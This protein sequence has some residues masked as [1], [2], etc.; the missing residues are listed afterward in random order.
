MSM[1][2]D[3]DD[4]R[5]RL[6]EAV[7]AR[8]DG[9]PE[10]SAAR[11]EAML[12]DFPGD[13]AVTLEYAR[14]MT[15]LGKAELADPP[16]E[17]AIEK[18]P[19]NFELRAMWA[20]MPLFDCDWTELG[21]RGNT[22]RATFSAEQSAYHLIHE[23]LAL[24]ESFR[25]DDAAALVR[26]HWDVF[27]KTPRIFYHAID[28]LSSAVRTDELEAFLDAASF[29]AWSELP[30]EAPGNLRLRVEATR[31]NQA[32]IKASGVRLISLGQNC[33]PF[34][35][36]RRWGLNTP[37]HDFETLCPFDQ[38]A[39]HA[40][41]V[42]DAIATDFAA[43][44]DRDAY[45]PA[46]NHITRGYTLRHIPSAVPFYH[47]RGPYWLDN[48]RRRFFAH[49]ETMVENWRRLHKRGR[50]LFVFSLV[51]AGDLKRLID[52]AE[53]QLLDSQSHLLIIDVQKHRTECPVHERVTYLYAPYPDDYDW[54]SVP[55]QN[56]VGGIRF[57]S[58]I[59]NAISHLI[60]RLAQL[61]EKEASAAIGNV[62]GRTQRRMLD[63]ALAALARGDQKACTGILQSMQA[64]L[65]DDPDTA[66]N[67]SRALL[68]AGKYAESDSRLTA[69]IARFPEDFP[70]RKFWMERPL[71]LDNNWAEAIER[72]RWVRSLPLSSG[73]TA[74]L[75]CLTT[76]MSLLYNASRW[77]EAYA[78]VVENWNVCTSH[79]EVFPQALQLLDKLFQIEAAVSLLQ[80]VTPAAKAALP[81]DT[82][83]AIHRRLGIAIE[84]RRILENAGTT[85]LSLG[86]TSRPFLISGRWGLQ[87]G[88]A[89]PE[90][91]TPFDFCKFT[92]AAWAD[93]I[94]SDF[95]IF[96]DRSQYVGV[97]AEGGGW[98]L[99]HSLTGTSF[100]DQRGAYWLEKDAARF[101]AQWNKLVANWRARRS[102]GARIFLMFLADQ[103]N[104]AD[105]VEVA[106]EHLLDQTARLLIIDTRAQA[107]PAPRHQAVQYV[108]IPAPNRY[109]WDQFPDYNLPEAVEYERLLMSSVTSM[110]STPATAAFR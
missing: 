103:D 32:L 73:D 22:L 51:G 57:E 4:Y 108:H 54:I 99:R 12:V 39:F 67:E 101:F 21:R 90:E 7:E 66:L 50:R 23:L 96:D 97:P 47:W 34:Q 9:E 63:S 2:M 48:G 76:E 18:Y 24:R 80:D 82:L 89:R 13:L 26:A 107:E 37:P 110:L 83:D 1:T 86:R 31:K 30:P 70:L 85:V 92:T 28:A 56:T 19:T 105:I 77:E 91:L 17:T 106:T 5:R 93:A 61:P 71:F 43:Y 52:V 94:A 68:L 6:E 69:A 11:L 88:P 65:P 15:R 62:G 109:M 35:L 42:V 102:S 33:L 75:H 59:A 58:Q 53:K 38:G 104:L 84:N 87:G 41:S 72:V 25:W 98:M 14:T 79:E 49:W 3:D 27:T 40:N 45:G 60:S 16:L 20:D 81:R 46:Y 29:Q 55:H 95:T 100:F 36:P 64:W 78:L 8:D 44:D 10:E 74:T